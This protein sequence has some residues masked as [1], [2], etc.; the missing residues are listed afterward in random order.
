MKSTFSLLHAHPAPSA[1]IIWI[2]RTGARPTADAAIA[3]R[4]QRVTGQVVDIDVLGDPLIAPGEDGVVP[5]DSEFRGLLLAHGLPDRALAGTDAV[6]PDVMGA[7][8]GL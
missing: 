5:K 4:L 7:Q 6:D 2:R 1:L 3:T 8:D